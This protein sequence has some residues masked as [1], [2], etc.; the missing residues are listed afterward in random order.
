MALRLDGSPVTAPFDGI[1]KAWAVRGAQGRIALQ[2]LEPRDDGFSRFNGTRIVTVDGRDGTQRFRAD[3]LVP[4]GARFGI[5]I[6]PGGGVGIRS[7][8]D[9]AATA[10]FFGLLRRPAEVP[11]RRGGD[12]EELLLRVELVPRPGVRRQEEQAQEVVLPG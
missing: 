11:D 6:A 12:A 10:R 2:I 5:E 3:R 4:K 1:L 7:G 9:G 8:V